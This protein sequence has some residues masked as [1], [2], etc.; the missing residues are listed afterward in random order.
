[1]G[2]SLRKI[3]PCILS[4]LA[5]KSV[6]KIRLSGINAPERGQEFS[7]KATAALASKVKGK[8]LTVEMAGYDH[9]RRLLG[10]LM[11]DGESVDFWL[12][13]N[14]WAWQFVKYDQSEELR[15]AQKLAKDEGSG[16]WAGEANGVKPMPPLEYR[17]RKRTLSKIK[18]WRETPTTP[19]GTGSFWLNTSS[20]SRHNEGCRYYKNTKRGKPCRADEGRATSVTPYLTFDVS[21]EL[22]PA[23]PIV[24]VDARVTYLCHG[25]N[26]IRN[27]LEMQ[28]S[29]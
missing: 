5:G 22:L 8:Q 2:E 9:Y 6:Y 13:R 20:G 18:S 29:D 23:R 17:D 24:L 11:L 25:S 28:A 1:V 14:G 10:K 21:S 26:H 27:M 3:L 12:V 7:S 4:L 19:A 15:L 16:L